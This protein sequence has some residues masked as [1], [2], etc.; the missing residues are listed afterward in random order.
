M[1]IAYVWN[2]RKISAFAA[3]ALLLSSLSLGGC[4]T[5]TAGSSLMDARAEQPGHPKTTDYPAVE[6]VPPRPEKPAMTADEQLKLKKEL[7]ATRDRQATD[8]KAKA[9]AARAQPKKPTAPS[10]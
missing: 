5:S 3:A 4:A 7:S 10:Q 1:G 9:G 8:S 2:G 6:D